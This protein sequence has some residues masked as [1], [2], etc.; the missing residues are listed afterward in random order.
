MTGRARTLVVEDDPA[1]AVVHRGFV[2]SHPRFVVV[3]EARNGADALR[4]AAGLRP[5]LV[6]LDLH[7]PDIGGLDVL[8]RLRLLPGP[9]VDV[10]A[11]TAARELDSVRQAMAGGVVAYLVKPFTSAAL[12][13]R[14]DEVWQRREDLR[15]AEDTLDQ[16]AV[17]QLLAG[18]R[19]TALPPKGLSERSRALVQEALA[20]LCGSPGEAGSAAVPRDASAAEVAGAVG[21]SRVS[22][23]RYLEHLVREGLA[24]VTPRYGATGRPENRYRPT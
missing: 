7:L 12:R 11:T 15:R 13:D 8:R 2:E 6:L 17:D 10:V 4:L 21:M 9:P 22:A 19:A 16:D 3:G 14:L 20:R 18:P 24:Q 5:D 23:R 1:V